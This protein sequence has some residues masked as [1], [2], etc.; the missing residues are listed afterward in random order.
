M[1]SVG[2]HRIVDAEVDMDHIRLLLR[3]PHVARRGLGHH[4]WLIS[5]PDRVTDQHDFHVNISPV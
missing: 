3:H 4:Q 5:H 1:L 2:K